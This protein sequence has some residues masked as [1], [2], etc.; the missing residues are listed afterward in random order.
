MCGSVCGLTHGV[1][2]WVGVWVDVWVDVWVG[3]VCGRVS[4]C[5]SVWDRRLVCSPRRS[6]RLLSVRWPEAWRGSP[7]PPAVGRWSG[8]GRAVGRGLPAPPAVGR[9]ACERGRGESV[10]GP[11][12]SVGETRG[13]RVGSHRR[14]DRL[15]TPAV[16]AAAHQA[17]ASAR[18]AGTR[19]TRARQVLDARRQIVALRCG[20]LRSRRSAAATLPRCSTRSRGASRPAAMPA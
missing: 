7:A 11:D 5:G 13:R 16:R 1:G 2:V 19:Q 8:G 3:S 15:T 9:W 6:G 4:V 12:P 10:R 18:H 17:G 14:S 20:H